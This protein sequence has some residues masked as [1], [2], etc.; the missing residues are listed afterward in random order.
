MLCIINKRSRI[1]FI[2]IRS[3]KPHAEVTFIYL[4]LA[5]LVEG[6]RAQSPLVLKDQHEKSAGI[7]D[8]SQ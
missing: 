1:G 4:S 5:V 6:A 2:K 3:Q 7:Q 8:E